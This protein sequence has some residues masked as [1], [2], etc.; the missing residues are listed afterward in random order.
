M[1][2]QQVLFWVILVI[3]IGYLLFVVSQANAADRPLPYTITA[4]HVYT[5]K[6]TTTIEWYNTTPGTYIVY[7]KRDRCTPRYCIVSYQV[8]WLKYI[9]AGNVRVTDTKSAMSYYIKQR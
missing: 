7:A 9:R 5:H 4:P 1:R 2:K 8:I 3:I 6:H